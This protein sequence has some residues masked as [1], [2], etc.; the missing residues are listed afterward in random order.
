MTG[1]SDRG[2][3][4]D[5]PF[6]RATIAGN[7][8]KYAQ[9]A[10][11]RGHIMGDGPFTQACESLLERELGAK[12]VVLTTSCTHALELAAL[13][14]DI[15]PDDEVIVP[16]FTFPSTANAFVLRRARVVFAD[17]DP[18]TLNIDA[19][20]ARSLVSS[21]TR[22]LAP[23]HYGGVGCNMERL[24]S[25]AAEHGLWMV[26]DNAQGLFAEY[27]GQPLGTFGEFG[28]LSFHE[29][30]NFTSGE[31]GAL[32][33]RDEESVERAEIVREKGTNRANFLRGLVDKYTWV[34]IGSSYVPS[35]ITAAFLLAQ[36]EQREAIQQ[37]RARL[38]ERYASGLSDWARAND[39]RLP[40]VPEDVK[41]AYH[42]FY[43]LVPSAEMR[44]VMLAELQTRGIGAVFHYLPLHL[45]PVGR[46]FG[47]KPGD[48][49]VAEDA[50]ARLIR[51]PFY[52]S[53]DDAS[54]DR[55]IDEVRSFRA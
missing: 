44:N 8:L 15:E 47:A 20:H 26:E 35:D 33:V 37:A 50:S 39:V 23:V 30:K 13:L 34:D 52:Y 5:V 43:L 21:R 12:R 46:S 38:W 29:T 4:W 25:L 41:S 40:S 31:G 32:I 7:E 55:V 9:Q 54:Q 45:S 22:G 14:L 11:E 3:R 17:I 1:R 27:R 36:L 48:C 49:P 42:L 10:F 28:A 51:L 18:S 19:E 16:S 2:D 53:L 24:C 6:N